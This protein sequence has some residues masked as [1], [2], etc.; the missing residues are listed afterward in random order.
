MGEVASRR[1]ALA[2]QAAGGGAERWEAP[3]RLAFAQL[4]KQPA[5][6]AVA[7]HS[8]LWSLFFCSIEYEALCCGALSS[9]AW[10]SCVCFVR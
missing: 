10:I 4:E 7:Q 9:I 5:M 3:R 1:V 8:H 2:V 6:L